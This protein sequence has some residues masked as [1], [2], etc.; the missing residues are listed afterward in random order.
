MKG[1]W[2]LYIK[3]KDRFIGFA[4]RS[5]HE[6]GIVIPM[7]KY[8]II[9]AYPEKAD[10]KA[11]TGGFLIPIDE[12]SFY[13]VGCNVA[14]SLAGRRAMPLAACVHQIQAISA[15]IIHGDKDVR[16]GLKISRL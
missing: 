11:G 15:Y 16:G 6:N 2:D 12:Y 5:E 7:D 1:I 14:I 9:L 3:E 8:D 13:I 4:R 10:N